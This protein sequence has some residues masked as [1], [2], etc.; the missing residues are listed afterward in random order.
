[1]QVF[2]T[3]LPGVLVIEPRV[4]PDERGFFKETYHQQ[5]YADLGLP[6]SFVQD[7]YSHSVQGTI[8]ALHYQIEQPQGKLVQIFKGEIFDVAVD[9]RRDS[10]RFGEW[11][12]VLL[13]E[14]NHRQLYIPPGFAHG[15]CAMSDEADVLYKCTDLYAPQ[16]ERT[17]LWNDPSIG[18]EWPEVGTPIV[19]KKDQ[20]GQMLADA[21]TFAT[22]P[23]VSR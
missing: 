11:V 7:N 14:T 10:P 20:L 8:R 5:R 16:H 6:S 18:I 23:S 3:D 13:S 9:I 21:E 17:I 4:F 1:M 19:S 2:E 15:F 12:G 22:T